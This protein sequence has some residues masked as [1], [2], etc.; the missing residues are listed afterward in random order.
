MKSRDI[1]NYLLAML[2]GALIIFLLLMI[3]QDK[4]VFPFMTA[5]DS[6]HETNQTGEPVDVQHILLPDANVDVVYYFTTSNRDLTCRKIEKFMR[7]ALNGNFGQHC[8]DGLIVWRMIPV[9]LPAYRHF[10]DDYQLDGRSVVLV[11]IRGGKKIVWKK[12]D[13]LQMFLVNKTL[14]TDYVT[15]EV[16]SFLKGSLRGYALMNDTPVFATSFTME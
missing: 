7:D 6:S 15:D 9:D 2:E 13:S 10:I 12:L 5:N 16:N 1:K 8:S 3:F 11:K 14:F 4:L